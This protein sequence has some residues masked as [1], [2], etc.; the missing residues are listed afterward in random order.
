MTAPAAPSADP[1]RSQDA[2]RVS[3]HLVPR[4]MLRVGGLPFETAA[5][6]ATPASAAWADGVLDARPRLRE[7]GAR[8]A[9]TL[10]DRVARGL[11]DPAAR[12]R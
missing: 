7:R 5:G 4:F 11:D 1:A 3:W 12:R 6:L 8:L 2:D 9:D 10:Q